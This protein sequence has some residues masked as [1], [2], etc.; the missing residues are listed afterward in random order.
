MAAT[1]DMW[2]SM[3][4]G[5]SRDGFGFLLKDHINELG[6]QSISAPGS[7]KA[8]GEAHRLYGA[9]PWR[10][11]VQ[12]AIDVCRRGWIVRP[13]VEEFWPMGP[14][15][16]HAAH[17][18]RI[19]FSRTGPQLYFND[20]GKPKR[21]GKPVVNADYVRTPEMIGVEVMVPRVRVLGLGARPGPCCPYRTYRFFAYGPA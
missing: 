1:P 15:L 19:A 18:E 17:T 16:G 6:Y 14:D 13:H 21:V 2:L 12:P 8:F 10:D 3:L 11:V 9:L 7:L 4:E 20:D 5:E